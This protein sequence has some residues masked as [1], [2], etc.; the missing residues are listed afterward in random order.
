MKNVGKK[1]TYRA[2]YAMP[3]AGERDAFLAI[4]TDR[5][6]ERRDEDSH[7]ILS[8]LAVRRDVMS[9]TL[10][11]AACILAVGLALAFLT[12]PGSA[13]RSTGVRFLLMM[14]GVL[15]I[16]VFTGNSGVLSFAQVIFM[17]F[18][19]YA[20]ALLS[21]PVALKASILP[22]LPV[23]LGAFSMPFPLAMIAA[24]MIVLIIAMVIGVP[25]VRM[26]GAAAVI[27]TLGLLL[28]THSVLT[29]ARDYTRGSQVLYGLPPALGLAAVVC[30]CAAIVAIARLFKDT[31]PGLQLRASR[32]N[33]VAASAVGIDVV[34]VRYIA[35]IIAGGVGA[36]AG[37]LYG[38][39][40]GVFSPKEFYLELT[41]LLIV[42]AVVGG[43]SSVTGAV[44]GTATILGVIEVLRRLEE[45]FT[46]G[47]VTMPQLFGLTNFGLGLAI[48]AVLYW[49]KQGIVGFREIALPG[50]TRCETTRL[51]GLPDLLAARRGGVD[52]LK[53]EGLT[54]HFGGLVAVDNVSFEFRT[55]EI[56][57][58]IGPNGSGK[59][60]TVNMLS[61]AL[62][63]NG[64]TVTLAGRDITQLPMHERALLGLGRTFQNIAIFTNLSVIDNVRAAYRAANPEKAAADTEVHAIL[65][66]LDL[67]AVANQPAGQLA[68]GTQRRVEVARALALR[69]Q[70]LLLDEPAAGLD[71]DETEDL[72]EFLVK[73]RSD[74]GLGIVIID[75]DLRLIMQ[76]C[77]RIVVLNKGQKI[78]EGSPDD[79]RSDPNV[80]E[81][82]IGSKKAGTGK[83]TNNNNKG[84]K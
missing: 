72:L 81:S 37:A 7:G 50:S 48:L 73:L 29:G 9:S 16:S 58:L 40:L 27:A 11:L 55:G 53:V 76:L 4:I 83:I 47:P 32:E 10:L 42:M 36:V 3:G 28:M 31:A 38:N 33:E 67:G 24:L 60:T 77:D 80:I 34:R 19:A 1:I 17:A 70:F 6:A 74:I 26:S 82:Y 52:R 56:L 39:F 41:F 51:D 54:K 5:L 84:T 22:D 78:A 49:R 44:V 35:W 14:M 79:V 45:G 63:A 57:G 64:G 12:D 62:T 69:P 61:G 18:G 59:T 15:S 71:H 20:S 75:H 2:R 13:I 23:W 68:Y 30:I 21:I 8:L 65:D 46:L 66:N 25:I 43:F